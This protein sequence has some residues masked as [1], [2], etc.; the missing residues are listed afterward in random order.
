MDKRRLA[1]R[2]CTGRSRILEVGCSVGNVAWGL[3]QGRDFSYTGVDV[4]PVVIAYAQRTFAKHPNYRFICRDLA[5]L[6]PDY[7]R[8]DCI[9]FSGVCHHVDDHSCAQLLRAGAS[10]LDEGGIIVVIDPLLPRSTD[11]PLVRH[12][13]RIDQGSFVRSGPQLTGILTSVR[14]LR[15]EHAEE[16]YVTATPLRWPRVGRFGAYVLVPHPSDAESISR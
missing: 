5:S 15:I 10:L 8:F 3:D 6:P 9:L 14:G 1:L 13:I 11:P 16:T 12:F 4:D 2:F 7:G